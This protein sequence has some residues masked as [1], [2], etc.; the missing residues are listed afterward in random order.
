MVVNN[1]LNFKILFDQMPAT[2]TP[3]R[4]SFLKMMNYTKGLNK[5]VKPEELEEDWLEKKA[6]EPI[7]KKW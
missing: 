5:P 2:E 4:L 7:R 1:Y 6:P 3:F